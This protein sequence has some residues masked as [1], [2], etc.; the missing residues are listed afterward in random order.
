MKY[1]PT[2]FSGSECNPTPRNYP[3]RSKPW[4]PKSKETFV[5]VKLAGWSIK[6]VLAQILRD[7]ASH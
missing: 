3:T 5:T 1:Y 6:S 7:I 2:T 4:F